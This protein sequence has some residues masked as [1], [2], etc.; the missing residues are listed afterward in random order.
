MTDSPPQSLSR[1]PTLNAILKYK[2]HSSIHLIKIFSQSF[3][4]FYFSH[5]DKNT[6]PKEIKKL[7]FNKA[8]QESD[9]PVKI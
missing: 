3:L 4:R 9:I 2:T 1:H 7:N 6:V 5:V 8:V